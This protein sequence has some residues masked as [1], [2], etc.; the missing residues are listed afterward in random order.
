MLLQFWFQLVFQL[1][2]DVSILTSILVDV[3][4]GEVT[5]GTLV[6]SPWPDELVDVN[7]LVVQIYLGH[8]VHVVTQL[9]LDEIVGNH[10][11]P[12]LAAQLN[13]I[14]VQHL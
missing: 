11:I 3:G 10:S 1:Q 12:H 5:H 8:V 6:L 2:G 7:R 9:G 4:R 13:V 14:V